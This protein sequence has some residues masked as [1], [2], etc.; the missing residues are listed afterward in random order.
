MAPEYGATIGFF[1]VDSETLNYLRF[2]G[3]PPDLVNLVEAYTKEQGLFRIDATADPVFSDV[4][5]LV[6]G[7]VVPSLAGP[8][9]PQD[10][11]ILAGV[12]KNFQDT[13]QGMPA[14]KAEVL[15]DNGTRATIG[16][17]VVA[18]AAIT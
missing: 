14:R 18:I 13:I 16:H 9:R 1:P 15:L 2:T 4:I 8:K 17:G 12:M 11:L 6:L 5:E 7:P 10:R 3:R